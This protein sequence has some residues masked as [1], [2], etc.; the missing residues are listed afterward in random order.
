MR[1]QDV[2]TKRLNEKVFIHAVVFYGTHAMI[3]CIYSVHTISAHKV[4]PFP[5]S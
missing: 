5:V 1:A 3:V 2:V 4:A